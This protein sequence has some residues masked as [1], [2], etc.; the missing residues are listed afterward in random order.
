MSRESTREPVM[1]Y[2]LSFP[3]FDVSVF[4]AISIQDHSKIFN[5][6]KYREVLVEIFT[7]RNACRNADLN[8]TLVTERLTD[9]F[10]KTVKFRK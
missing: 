10:S 1:N 2:Q 4:K 3:E 6:T 9:H 8:L 5:L 7:A